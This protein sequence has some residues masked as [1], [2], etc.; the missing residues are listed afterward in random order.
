VSYNNINLNLEDNMSDLKAEIKAKYEE[1]K[2]ILKNLDECK[3]QLNGLVAEKKKNMED[4]KALG[5]KLK[6]EKA[7]SKR[8]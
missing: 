1:R 7:A 2:T 4:I 6:T 8:A 3:K 5:E